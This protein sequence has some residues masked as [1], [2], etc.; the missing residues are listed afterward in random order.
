VDLERDVGVGVESLGTELDDAEV[1]GLGDEVVAPEV[2]HQWGDVEVDEREVC[3]RQ[4]GVG[5]LAPV[6][7]AGGEM[8]AVRKRMELASEDFQPQTSDGVKAASCW[9]YEGLTR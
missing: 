6:V 1:G 3:G 9:R 8:A 7:L 5:C 4:P 2:V